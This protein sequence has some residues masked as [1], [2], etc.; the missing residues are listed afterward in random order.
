M[1]RT[2]VC[3]DYL[4]PGTLD[5]LADLGAL[6]TV[7]ANSVP[8]SVVSMAGFGIG[9]I[10]M[11]LPGRGG[12]AIARARFDELMLGCAQGAGAELVHATFIGAT[13]KRDGVEVAF[14]DADGVE[15][16]IAARVL[17][18]AD[19][20]WSTVA[21]RCGMVATQRGGGRWAVGGH[22]D[23]GRMN[24]TAEVGEVEMY[25]GPEGYYA[26]NPLGGGLVNSMLVMT[27]PIIDAEADEV[28]ARLSGGRRR[29]EAGALL[30]RVAVGPLRY[31]ARTA[32]ANRVVLTGDAAELLDPFLGQGVALATGLAPAA[33][34]A[35]VD[36]V[37]GRP[38]HV[39]ARRYAAQRAAAIRP[40]RLAA[41]AVDAI[42]RTDFL[43]RRA[44]RNIE[45]RPELAEALLAAVVDA[46]RGAG[47][48]A[49]LVWGLL[50]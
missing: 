38:A 44:A 24:S 39:V 23:V 17:V 21:Q 31:R 9:P 34:D 45:R 41:R 3:G 43:R 13:E 11:R 25:V 15:R 46:P 5:T 27:R 22:L 18:G 30:R 48:R 42:L 28:V 32:M 40:V 47:V 4:S 50:A 6:E 19:G 7:R 20:A 8:V 29:F 37:A 35:V 33:A 12:L 10:R 26:R 36:L 16:S 1:P 14:R 2:K 49:P